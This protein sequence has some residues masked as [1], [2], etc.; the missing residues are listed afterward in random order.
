MALTNNSVKRLKIHTTSFRHT[1]PQGDKLW[2][3]AETL[4]ISRGEVLSKIMDC[5]LQN[6]LELISD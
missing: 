2:K 4:K 5:P 1:K 3:L 6:I